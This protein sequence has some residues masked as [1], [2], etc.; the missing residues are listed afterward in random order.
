MPF[1][2]L[3]IWWANSK[4]QCPNSLLMQHCRAGLSQPSF[5][6][7]A[8]RTEP[9]RLPHPMQALCSHVQGSLGNLTQDHSDALHT[10]QPTRCTAMLTHCRRAGHAGDIRD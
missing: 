3:C 7:L 2:V 5:Q 6:T 1:S 10:L 8:A 4:W 9:G